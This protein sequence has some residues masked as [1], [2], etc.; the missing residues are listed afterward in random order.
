MKQ[1]WL[2]LDSDSLYGLSVRFVCGWIRCGICSPYPSYMIVRIR[3]LHSTLIQYGLMFKTDMGD[4]GRVILA[5]AGV[6]TPR[7][8]QVPFI[9]TA[10]G[11]DTLIVYV[12][13]E[14]AYGFCYWSN[15]EFTVDLD[16]LRDVLWSQN[17]ESL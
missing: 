6:A 12:T 7:T 17:V 13:G 1:A 8:G 3:D 16:S 9:I 11:L 14:S 2:S 10:V 5:S 15:C 4:T